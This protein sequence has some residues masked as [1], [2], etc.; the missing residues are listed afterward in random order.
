MLC[1]CM[2]LKYMCK[3]SL[4]KECE[5]LGILLLANLN[6][7]FLLAVYTFL[8]LFNWVR[9]FHAIPDVKYFNT[10]ANTACLYYNNYVCNKQ[11]HQLHWQF[12]F[13]YPAAILS[14]LSDSIR[15]SVGISY[16]KIYD[17]RAVTCDVSQILEAI[18]KWI[19]I[20]NSTID[21]CHNEKFKL[22]LPWCMYISQLNQNE[23]WMLAQQRFVGLSPESRHK[24]P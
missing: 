15:F 11:L 24:T 14:S 5:Y 2:A 8:G 20:S 4:I 16:R 7:Q 18:D 17:A 9:P 21:F 23:V 22:K 13:H 3:P 12:L 10:K 6:S 19:Y 1:M